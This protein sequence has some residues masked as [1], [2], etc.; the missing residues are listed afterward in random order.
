MKFWTE[1][2]FELFLETS[3][4]L[5]VALK[6]E[7]ELSPIKLETQKRLK[8]THLHITHKSRKEKWKIEKTSQ[9]PSTLKLLSRV[10]RLRPIQ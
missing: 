3:F 6:S 2:L 7:L 8:G 4:L 5:D 10:Q 9:L 1:L